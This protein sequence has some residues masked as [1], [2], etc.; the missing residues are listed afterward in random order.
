MTVKLELM[1]T[2]RNSAENKSIF[3]KMR[4]RTQ[5]KSK[6]LR[7][8]GHKE[9]KSAVLAKKWKSRSDD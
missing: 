3:K 8:E 9:G 6:F 5:A 2:K 7:E 4:E 1:Q